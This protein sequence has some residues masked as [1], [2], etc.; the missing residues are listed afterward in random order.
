ML[1]ELQVNLSI[2]HFQ[3]IILQVP[4]IFLKIIKIITI[5]ITSS[6][7]GAGGSLRPPRMLQIDVSESSS[8]I[9][10]LGI[11]S[12]PIFLIFQG[13]NLVYAGSI[14]GRNV[15]IDST[16]KPQVMLIESNFRD[17]IT[18]E[19]TLRKLGC[20]PF[21]CLSS[22]SGVNPKFESV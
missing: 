6:S 7:G 2:V 4:I 1:F 3:Q 18:C 12:L 21:L 13:S 8:V 9:K 15:K 14:G 20:E 11:K 16:H 5:N 10:E 19:K 22:V 17:Q